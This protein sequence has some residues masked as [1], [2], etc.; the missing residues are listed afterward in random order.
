MPEKLTKI[1]DETLQIEH[2]KT[3][4]VKKKDLLNDRIALLEQIAE[5]QKELD[6]TDAKLTVLE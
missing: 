1:D 4:E 3:I 2:T 6:E 5:L